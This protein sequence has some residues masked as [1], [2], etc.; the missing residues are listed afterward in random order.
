MGVWIVEYVLIALAIAAW[1]HGSAQPSM[2]KID[3][4]YKIMIDLDIYT[5]SR[6]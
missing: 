6:T 4:S 2:R 1:H 5:I 3:V